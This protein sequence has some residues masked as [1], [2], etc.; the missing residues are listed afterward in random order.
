MELAPF[1]LNYK[2]SE[3]GHD[4]FIEHEFT[5]ACAMGA[6][7]ARFNATSDTVASNGLAQW[8]ICLPRR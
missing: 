8:Q 3:H 5:V 1:A 7:W 6:S 4:G 2:L